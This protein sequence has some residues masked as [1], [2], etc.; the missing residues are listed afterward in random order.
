LEIPPPGA[1]KESCDLMKD[2]EEVK[3][4]ND[5]IKHSADTNPDTQQ[6]DTS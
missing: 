4:E 5:V 2:G 1:E 6:S 3:T